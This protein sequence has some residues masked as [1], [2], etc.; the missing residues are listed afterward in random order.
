[1]TENH[2]AMLSALTTY[3]LSSH[4][5]EDEDVAQMTRETTRLQRE[6]GFNPT[7]L[8]AAQVVII[9]GSLVSAVPTVFWVVA[10]VFSNIGLLTRLR[11]EVLAAVTITKDEASG[12][13]RVLITTDR[14]ESRCPILTAAFREAQRLAA[15]GTLHRRVLNDTEITATV[16]GARMTYLLKKGTAVLVPVVPSHR[17]YEAWGDE[18]DEFDV[19]RFLAEDMKGVQ[20]TQ[21]NVG[22][23]KKV[24]MSRKKAY[25]PF[26]GGKELCPG[27]N[28]AT[29]EALGTL[30][31]LVLGFDISAP[32]GSVL[33]LPPQ[34]FSKMTSQTARP[35]ETADLRASVKRREGWENVIWGVSRD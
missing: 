7:D 18:V 6:R 26:G 19:N 11:D 20:A 1:M 2:G 32:D 5:L 25:F 29:A 30:V 21:G 14:I 4:D 28:F 23:I 22:G 27:R 24:S 35:L 10:H 12:M 34:G 3:F 16:G 13:R 33:K 8:A 15:V 31:V 17:N 9:H